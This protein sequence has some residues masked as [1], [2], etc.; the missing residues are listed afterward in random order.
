MP[1]TW[2]IRDQVL[3][4]TTV[5]PYPSEQLAAAVKEA[6]ESPG[7]KRGLPIL[8]D[9]RL[10]QSTLSP[11]DVDWRERWLR[12]LVKGGFTNRCA[13]LLATSDLFRF[14]V[15]RMLS[16][17]LEPQGVHLSVYLDEREASRWAKSGQQAGGA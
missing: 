11:A 3:V 16:G 9:G 15:A 1:V 10:S 8:F 7:F 4:G 5:G 13:V 14:G 6:V 12:S 17:R 2:E